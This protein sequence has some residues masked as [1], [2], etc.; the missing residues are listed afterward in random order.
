[1]RPRRPAGP[2][3][4]WTASWRATFRSTPRSDAVGGGS[5]AIERLTPAD[6]DAVRAIYLERIATGNATFET[7]APSWEIWDGA[8][9][10]VA[11]LV[12]RRSGRV[13]GWAALTR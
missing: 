12:A 9:R 11:R 2:S 3:C 10:Q 5:F 13:V 7:D 8:H 4:R 6:W 1:M